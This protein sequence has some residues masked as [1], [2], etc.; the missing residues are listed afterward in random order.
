[1]L[2]MLVFGQILSKKGSET[3]ILSIYASNS[4]EP[5]VFYGQNTAKLGFFGQIFGNPHFEHLSLQFC[6]TS[7]VLWQDGHVR[8]TPRRGFG[9]G[10]GVVFSFYSK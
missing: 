6:R 7:G 10:F 4:A 2:E 9:L 8:G 3:L 1:M 5:V